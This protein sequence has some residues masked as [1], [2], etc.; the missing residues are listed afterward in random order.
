[1]REGVKDDREH[2]EG[3]LEA[4]DMAWW[5][6]EFPSGALKFSRF[7]TDVLGYDAKDFAHFTHFTDLIHSEDKDAAMQAMTDHYTGKKHTYDT[8]YRIKA[9]DGKYQTFHDKGKI[10]ERNGDSFIVA[11]VVQRVK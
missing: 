8:T 2:I 7:K 6:L 10:V 11:G 1:M 5:S 9:S 4:A 3:A